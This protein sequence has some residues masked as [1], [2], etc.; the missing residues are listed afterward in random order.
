V[1][2]STTNSM[3]SFNHQMLGFNE[4][5]NLFAGLE[6]KPE[7]DYQKIYQTYARPLTAKTMKSVNIAKTF[8]HA[9]GDWLMYSENN[10]A[11]VILDVV[12]GYGS[13]LLGHK[14]PLLHQHFISL[15]ESSGSN[16]IQ[17]SIRMNTALLTEKLSALLSRETKNGPWITTLSNSG[18][19]AVEAA[20]KHSY[21]NYFAKIESTQQEFTYKFNEVANHFNLT[22]PAESLSL[23]L[24]E[25][26]KAFEENLSKRPYL[27]A[28][29]HSYHG[30][31]LGSLKITSG[32]KYRTPFFL[33]DEYNQDVI[34]LPRNATKVEIQTILDPYILK[35]EI[36]VL[37]NGRLKIVQ[38]S[39]SPFAAIIAEPVQ[40][41]AGIFELDRDFLLSLRD[42][43][44]SHSVP[45]IFDEIQC[46]T[47][48]CGHMSAATSK[49]IFADIYIFSKS[50]GGGLA[51]IGATSIRSDIYNDRFGF[52][53]TSTFAEDDLSSGVA[54]KV[55]ELIE[56]NPHL[57]Q[58]GMETGHKI[59][60]ALVQLQKDFPL[61]IKDVRGQGLM[62]AIEFEEKLSMLGYE[63]KSMIDSNMYGYILCSC[64]LNKEQIRT[65]PSLSN[66]GT[67]R[68]QPSLY[69]EQEQV[70]M[71]LRGIRNLC[72]NLE[73]SNLYYFL[74]SMYPNQIIQNAEPSNSSF[75]I[76]DNGLPLAIF[77]SHP[78]DENHIKSFTPTLRKVDNEYLKEKIN[79]AKDFFDFSIFY[80]QTLK[81]KNGKEINIALMSVGITSSELKDFYNSNKKYRLISKL[82]D[83]VDY[84]KE[85][86]ASTVGLGQFTSIV[87]GNGLYLDS[88]GMNITTGN[89]LTV[90]IAIQSAVASAQKKGVDIQ[91]SCVALI[92]AAGN[93]ISTAASLV[94]DS[95]RRI[96]LLYHTPIE[97][98]AKLQHAVRSILLDIQ[99]SS[100]TNLLVTHLKSMLNSTS[101]HTQED[102]INFVNSDRCREFFVVSSNQE[103]ISSADIIIA[104]ANSST[105]VVSYKNLKQGAVFVDIAVPASFS[106][107][108]LA[109]MKK[110]R[111]D[112][113][114]QLGGIAQIPNSQSID[115]RCF[116]LQPG[117]IFACMAET[118]CIGFSGKK[119]ISNTGNITKKWFRKLTSLQDQL[120]LNYLGQK[121][122]HQCSEYEIKT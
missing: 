23:R 61:I 69:F 12:G 77:M 99:K 88:K 66:T 105:S 110:E 39:F 18:T 41:E 21:L 35:L 16:L 25:C 43:A 89:A 92:G 109:T 26:K 53:H 58:Q 97:K 33:G 8:T 86:G 122:L 116:P 7:I 15:V 38:Q 111:P 24:S 31:S 54:L 91:Q 72:L 14:N 74:S 5:F 120:V 106:K 52:L 11:K 50:L 1:T 82:Q 67:L 46:G 9:Q 13:N 6:S 51:K 44:T 83:A 90:S 73:Q 85:L 121:N 42:C 87:S 32:E 94:A 30:K 49:N 55:L 34:F 75:T 114:Y 117:Q 40:G 81:D 48:R 45:L 70:E 119:D 103:D 112:V 108:D 115:T 84:A 29:E 96:I 22:D 100:S 95:A 57:L 3:G 113:S 63:F 68:I 56:E 98:S 104:G 59:K 79:S 28:I 19:E 60:A 80:A 37:I 17:G 76:P 78:I 2:T 20:L 62:L 65:L 101:F 10:E 64:L 47:F 107:E 4:Q 118:F 93:I 71:L 27:I 36:P 102:L